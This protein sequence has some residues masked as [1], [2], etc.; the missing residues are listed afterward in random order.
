[1]ERGQANPTLHNILAKL[2]GVVDP[3]T[4]PSTACPHA[5]HYTHRAGRVTTDTAITVGMA[6]L[7]RSHVE[8]GAGPVGQ[9]VLWS[10]LLALLIDAQLSIAIGSVC[11]A[12][13][14][15]HAR[16][17]LTRPGQPLPGSFVT[18][19]CSTTSGPRR[20]SRGER[21]SF[22]LASGGFLLSLSTSTRSDTSR[23][24]DSSA[25]AVRCSLPRVVHV[26]F[27]DLASWRSSCGRAALSAGDEDDPQ[28]Q[29]LA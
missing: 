8:K 18:S 3:A 20:E 12:E 17:G 16:P 4:S 2:S 9:V 29:P 14:Q 22:T 24:T 28:V 19:V 26:D 7:S 25:T 21:M 27:G 6:G 1:V 10:S 15:Y 5:R 23:R 13:G 11:V